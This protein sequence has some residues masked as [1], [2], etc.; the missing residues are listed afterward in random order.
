MKS[1]GWREKL[2]VSL[3]VAFLAW[4]SVVFCFKTTAEFGLGSF[5]RVLSSTATEPWQQR[6][7]SPLAIGGIITLS[8]GAVSPETAER[9]FY[10]FA[11]FAL[12]Y[13]YYF[14]LRDYFGPDFSLL[15]LVF[16]AFSLCTAWLFDISFRPIPPHGWRYCYDVPGL[17]FNIGL[18]HAATSNKKWLWLLLLPIGI[19][20]RET[21]IAFIPVLFLFSL[22]SHGWRQAI[23]WGIISI[24][25]ACGIYGFLMHYFP[26]AL[27]QNHFKDN[28]SVLTGHYG[29]APILFI[30]S[31]Y[32]GL[33]IFIPLG[34][35]AS[36]YD[37]K[38]LTVYA[39]IGL[40]CIMIVGNIFEIRVYND[41]APFLIPMGLLGWRKAMTSPKIEV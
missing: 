32:V 41:Y 21:V 25:L 28:L 14:W 18:V 12:Y 33:L 1:S 17:I 2:V 10:Y 31:T 24:V 7:L 16:L 34:F 27:F 22:K 39:L 8:K 3:L 37:F 29:I 38:V 35:Q 6:M 5:K 11:I 23:L 4:V 36:P 13:L 19:V 30:L 20:N 9:A 26:G 40:A 15:C